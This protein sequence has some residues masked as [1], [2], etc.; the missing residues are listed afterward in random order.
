MI[1][2]DYSDA[3]SAIFRNLRVLNEREADIK[4]SFMR[5]SDIR[6]EVRG[7]IKVTKQDYTTTERVLKKY[8]KFL[9]K[10]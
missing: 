6:E 4:H 1:A 10:S 9:S 3:G 2:G 5:G 8:L 7:F